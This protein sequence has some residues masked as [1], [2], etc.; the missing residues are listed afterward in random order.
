ML[1][2]RTGGVGESFIYAVIGLPERFGMAILQQPKLAGPI[3]RSTLQT[4][5]WILRRKA[6]NARRGVKN[7][8]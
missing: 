1:Q 4:N 6:G 5:R 8:A 7:L 2:N 3:A